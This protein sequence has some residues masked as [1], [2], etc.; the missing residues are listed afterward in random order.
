MKQ[1]L[2]AVCQIYISRLKVREFNWGLYVSI[3]GPSHQQIQSQI[4]TLQSGAKTSQPAGAGSLQTLD[5]PSSVQNIDFN[6]TAV[7][8]WKLSGRY[9]WEA[10]IKILEISRESQLIQPDT[11]RFNQSIND[12]LVQ[13]ATFKLLLMLVAFFNYTSAALPSWTKSSCR[14]NNQSLNSSIARQSQIPTPLT[15]SI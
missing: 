9:G 2:A 15:R 7:P 3:R 4:P 6:S 11:N 10:L 14:L 8:L 13:F 1:A 12:F 5:F